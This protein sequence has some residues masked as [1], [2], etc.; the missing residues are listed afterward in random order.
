[1]SYMLLIVEPIGQ[2]RERGR[3]GGELAYARMRQ[4]AEE[5]QARGVLRAAESLAGTAGATRVQQ[6]DGRRLQFDGPFSEAKEMVGGF[7]L[8]DGVD[9]E[10]ALAIAAQ[11]PAAEWAT[12]E[13]RQVAPC[14]VEG[15]E[16]EASGSTEI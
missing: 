12:V 10:G 1:M 16:L 9:R 11:C 3:A 15:D 2:R 14:W 7:F 8:L 13:V 5:L 4:F 6:R